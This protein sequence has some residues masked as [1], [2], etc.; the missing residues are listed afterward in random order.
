MKSRFL[1]VL[2]VVCSLPSMAQVQSIMIAA[3]TPEDAAIQS[4]SKEPDD[5]KRLAMWEE[6]VTKFATNP[7]AVAYGDSQ[8][9]QQ[10]LNTGDAAKAL[11]YGEKA[12]AAVPNNLD[13]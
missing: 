11:S 7:A 8:I 6:F 3:G 13:I 5:A 4:I 10:Y 2:I 1:A 12:M 9:A